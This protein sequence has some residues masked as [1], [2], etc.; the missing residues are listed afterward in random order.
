MRYG[1]QYR[2]A[3]SLIGGKEAAAAAAKYLEDRVFGCDA[4][5]ILNA[6]SDTE[7]GLP[8]PNL[9]RRWPSFVEIVAARVERAVSPSLSPRTHS[10][11]RF[12]RR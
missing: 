4:A 1:D 9:N 10:R 7:L 5:L 11:Y 6:I 2:E 12:S 8:E 3:F